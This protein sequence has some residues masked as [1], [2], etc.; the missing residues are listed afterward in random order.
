MHQLPPRPPTRAT[1]P[2]AVL[3]WTVVAHAP[4]RQSQFDVIIPI[5][6]PNSYTRRHGIV[7]PLMKPMCESF[8]ESAQLPGVRPP[9]VRQYSI[10]PASIQTPPTVKSLWF[11]LTPP[12]SGRVNL[13]RTPLTAHPS[14][15]MSTPA[16]ALSPIPRIR[17]QAFFGHPLSQPPIPSQVR[18]PLAA[19]SLGIVP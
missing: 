8:P 7:Q 4:A 9:Y 19:S 14:R 18:R 16:R 13:V 11:I 12:S 10:L 6:A 5:S 3:A 15:L 1:V 2:R 17:E